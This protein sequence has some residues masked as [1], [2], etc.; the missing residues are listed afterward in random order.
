MLLA[1]D[2]WINND[3]KKFISFSAAAIIIFRA[4]LALLLGLMLLYDLIYKRITI[5]E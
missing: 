1:I 5:K 4:E 2:G 3:N